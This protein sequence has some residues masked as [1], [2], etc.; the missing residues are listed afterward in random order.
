MIL[1]QTMMVAA[2]LVS[3]MGVALLGSVKVPLARRLQIDEA[4]V[5]GLVSVFGFTMIP[6]IFT[7]GF[8]TDLVGRQMVMVGGSVLMAVSLLTLGRAR[9]YSWALAAVV[10]M[11]ASWA[12]MINVGNVLTPVAFP[13][14]TTAYSTN[15]ANVFFGIGAFLTPLAIA[16]LVER[17]TLGPTLVLIGCLTLVPGGLALGVD[18][19]ATVSATSGPATEGPGMA[20]LLGDPVLWLC[21]LAL[22]FYGPLEA[23]MAA[24]TTTYL[25]ERGVPEQKAARLLSAFWLTFMGSRLLAAFTLPGGQ[26]AL[27]ILGLALAATAV[28]L[29]VVL[30][31][32]RGTAVAAVMAAGLV[33]GPIFP[34]VMAI[35]LGHFPESVHGRAVGLF[36]AV[37]GV[38]WT[39]IPILI[40]VYAK[41]TSVQRGLTVAVGAAVGLSAVALV[42]L[43]R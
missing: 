11:S 24:W 36:F 7:A 33:L 1:L 10:L 35:L 32:T 42:L 5:G 43:L 19:G 39:V 37:G 26:E 21:G 34:T 27:V 22:F 17:L 29:A 4:R 6:V 31:R 25:G 13:G 28:M 30:S 3:G 16:A 14:E 8:L 40:G 15:L 20:T 9:T 18:F 2:L 41:R 12:L 23:S 38:G